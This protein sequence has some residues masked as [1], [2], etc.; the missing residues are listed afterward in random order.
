[1]MMGI[2]W[3][4]A[5]FIWTRARVFQI[6]G[7]PGSGALSTNFY[8]KETKAFKGTISRRSVTPTPYGVFY[9]AEDGLRVFNGESSERVSNPVED[10]INGRNIMD[11]PEALSVGEYHDDKFIFSYAV[12]GSLVPN[13]CVIFDFVRKEWTVHAKGY[14]DLVADRKNNTM[15]C[16]TQTGIERFRA[17][18]WYAAWAA[19]TRDITTQTDSYSAF[20]KFQVDMVGSCSAEVYYDDVL[21]ES[22]TLEATTR[23]LVTRRFPA[24][25]AQRA[26]I[27][28]VG[29][30][31][32]TPQDIIYGISPSGEVQRGKV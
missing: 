21:T 9:Q 20:G 1:M 16:A 11:G 4:A 25:L 32:T 5:A 22:Y 14:N 19:R 10:E 23:Q 8:I 24:G 31:K 12:A 17:G 15:Y 27:R 7:S 3:N 29:S 6:V 26:A 28:L 13:R 30:R 18:D 2:S